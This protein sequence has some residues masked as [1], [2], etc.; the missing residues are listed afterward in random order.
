MIALI[1]K[2]WQKRKFNAA[3]RIADAKAKSDGRRYW[4]FVL[5]G[6]TYILNNIMLH[7]LKSK[8]VFRSDLSL[9]QIKKTSLYSTK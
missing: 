5:Q 9:G 6:K 1:K 3:I 2:W 7:E 4:V 8:G